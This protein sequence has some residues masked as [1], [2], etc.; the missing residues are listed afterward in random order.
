MPT[1]ASNVLPTRTPSPSC[2]TV[3][4][5]RSSRSRQPLCFVLC[6]IDLFKQVNDTHGH[7]VGDFV[8]QSTARFFR[9]QI[10]EVDQVARWGGEEFVFLLVDTSAVGART[11]ADK[12]RSQLTE[13]RWVFEGK[14]LEITATF[15]V[16]PLDAGM[17]FDTCVKRADQAMCRGKS[18]GRNRVVVAAS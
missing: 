9:K 5:S 16:C 3:A 2:P 8:L 4:R 17:D 14:E 15:G 12:I 11:I 13:Q 7:E 10:R 1:G 6:D 18:E